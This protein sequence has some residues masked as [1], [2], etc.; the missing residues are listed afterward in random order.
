MADF[1][2]SGVIALDTETTGLK[3]PQDRA[4]GVSLHNGRRGLYID[5]RTDRGA[6]RQLARDLQKVNRIVCHNALFDIKMLC[7]AGIN[8]PLEKF[9]CTMTRAGLINEHEHSYS[10]DALAEKHLGERKD[11][12][13]YDEMAAMFGGRATRA[14][15]M[16][17]IA[18][19]PADIVARYAVRDAELT[20]LLWQWQEQEIERQGIRRIVEFERSLIPTF[21]RATMRG[22]RVDTDRAEEAAASLTPLIDELKQKLDRAAGGDFNPNS[23]PQV[24]A[25]FQPQYR[26]GEWWS[27]PVMLEKT[28]KGQPSI[29]ANALRRLAQYRDEAKWIMEYRSLVKTRDTFLLGHVV[30]HAYRGRVYPTINQ[31]KSEH[32]GT[33]TGRLSYQEPAMQQIPSRNKK[34]AAIVKP[35]FLPE[36]GQ[37]WL[38]CDESSFEVRVFAS[39]IR[40]PEIIKRYKEDPATD[41]HQAVADLT[42]LPRNASYNGEPNAKQLNLCVDGETEYLAEGHVWKKIRDYAG[43]KIA[44]WN[45]DGTI[46]FVQP[47][48]YHKGW[49]DDVYEIKSKW[50]SLVCTGDHRLP[51]LSPAQNR[52]N[53]K[54][55]KVRDMAKVPKR[56]FSLATTWKSPLGPGADM[57]DDE[58][59]LAV[60]WQA[61]GC[62]AKT[63]CSFSFRKKRKIN[64]MI[65][66]LNRMG[67]KYNVTENCNGTRIGLISDKP[68]T[69]YH[70]KH[71]WDEVKWRIKKFRGSEL[72]KMNL[73]QM[74]VFL[75]E[76]VHWDG[77]NNTAGPESFTYVSKNKDN[78]D[79]AALVCHSLGWPANVG[80]QNGSWKA[81]LKI[82]KRRSVMSYNIKQTSPRSVYCFTVPSSWWVARRE[83]TI[84]ITGNSMIF[85]SG[86]GAIAEK[87]GMDWYWDQFERNGGIIRYKKAGP[88]AM[89]VINT[90]HRMLPGVKQLASEQ[91]GLAVANGYIENQFGRR[92]RFP[93]GRNTYKASG[94]LIQST[95]ADL[96]KENWKLIEEAI[97]D[98]GYLIL[99]T[100]DS[101]SMSVPEDWEPV[102]DRVKEL[103]DRP[104]R[105]PDIPL[106]LELSG[107]G[108]DW[109]DAI[110]E[111][112]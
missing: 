56:S 11:T 88:E 93:G 37:K 53:L 77:S 26:D 16:P 104:G 105:L 34:V 32:G 17:R 55:R 107:V 27:G 48:Y 14:V 69:G 91:E 81:Y 44:Q 38:D 18:Q 24:R 79:F 15:Q 100:H 65:Q 80:P 98:D 5:L 12:D 89:A 58:I 70:G 30:G 60:A 49:S 74:E 95:A 52:Y 54:E 25:L 75:D 19:A 36:E 86:N 66:L 6:A 33:G 82:S 68:M 1:Q 96:N 39:L 7:A 102:W 9:E 41:F 78:V 87:M 28:K 64:R 85:N 76:L 71:W 4:F 103:L 61:D 97:G 20:L 45:P 101:Y 63:S 94:I 46:E 110:R 59:R 111:D 8:A 72:E 2:F 29:D 3:Y 40:S 22:I 10:L 112:K 92:L 106:L 57:T 109:W 47:S 21:A 99:N 62:H 35:C 108:D 83:N 51:V 84:H 23:S 90:Y 43:E 42:G 31:G 50:G 13:I 73:H 67:I